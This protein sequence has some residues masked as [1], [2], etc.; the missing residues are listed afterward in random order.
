MMAPLS[1]PWGQEMILVV[2]KS[3]E[4]CVLPGLGHE[5]GCSSPTSLQ[6]ACGAHGH[7]WCDAGCHPG[8]VTHVVSSMAP[9]LP[10]PTTVPTVGA[11]GV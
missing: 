9:C 3:A 5:M 10:L 8:E 7:D 2:M 4:L 1:D 11:G 6:A